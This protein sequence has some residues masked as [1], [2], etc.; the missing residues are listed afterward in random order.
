MKAKRLLSVLVALCML[1]C[2]LPA[3]VSVPVGASQKADGANRGYFE[4]NGYKIWAPSNEFIRLYVLDGGGKGDY[5]SKTEQC[6]QS[7]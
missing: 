1:L 4:H 3:N 6:F 7:A 2:M 5:S